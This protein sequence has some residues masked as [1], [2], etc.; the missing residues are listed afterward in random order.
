MLTIY[1]V[2]RSRATRNIW[3]L[4]EIGKDF[5][6]VPVI[7]AYRLKDAGAAGGPMNTLSPEFLAISPA[8]AVPVMKDGDLVLSESLAINLYIARTYGGAFGPATPAEDALMQQWS[9][10]AATAIEPHSIGIYQANSEH[11]VGTPAARAKIDRIVTTLRRPLAVLDAALSASPWLV[12]GRFTVA[13]INVAEILR[14]AQAEAG[15]V[16][17]FPAVDRWIRT[18][19]ARPAFKAMW[20]Q[21]IAEPE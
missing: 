1:G 20:A 17:A 11:G 8:G 19:Q 14:Y 2:A 21:R 16:E 3:L 10:Y 15:L 12:G 4:K 18:C 7:Q 5:A 9:F 13:D 6:Q